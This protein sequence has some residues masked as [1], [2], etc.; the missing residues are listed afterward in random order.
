M[1]AW[2]VGRPAREARVAGAEWATGEVLQGLGDRVRARRRGEPWRAV[3][4]G[5]TQFI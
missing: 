3:G 5:R 2:R 1:A 4:K